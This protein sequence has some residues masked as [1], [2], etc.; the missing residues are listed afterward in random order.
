MKKYKTYDGGKSGNGT[1]QHIINH[2]PKCN[3]YI[4]PFF[5]NGG[6][7][8]N[9]KRPA[10]SIINDINPGVIDGLVYDGSTK[11]FNKDFQEVIDEYDCISHG[12]FYYLDPPYLFETRKSQRRLYKYEMDIKG[13]ERLLT[14]ALIVNNNCM[15]SHYPC[16]MYDSYLKDWHTFDFQSTTRNGV[17]TERIYMNYPKPDILQDFRYLGTNFTDRQRIKRKID[18]QL[19]KLE[20]LPIL[21]RTGILSALIDKYNSASMQLIRKE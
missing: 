2:I 12:V 10:L 14:K 11:V 21:E 3:I 7:Y 17:R 16:E 5:G 4:E 13:H 20:S 8:H 1:Y 18:R 15:I 9:L 19:K 6:V